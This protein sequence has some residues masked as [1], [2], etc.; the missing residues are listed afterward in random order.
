MQNRTG[1]ET[2]GKELGARGNMTERE[3]SFREKMVGLGTRM[4]EWQKD[5]EARKHYDEEALEKLIGEK[6][7]GRQQLKERLRKE[8]EKIHE[9]VT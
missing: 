8:E 7:Q 2:P 9:H 6:P 3:K 4:N 5:L 1:V